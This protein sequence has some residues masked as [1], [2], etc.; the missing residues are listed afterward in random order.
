MMYMIFQFSAQTGEVSGQLS[1]D[2]SYKIVEIKD[3]LLGTEKSYEDLAAEADSIHYY[4]RKAAH[5]TVYFLLAIAVSFPCMYTGCGESGSCF[6]PALSVWVLRDL[7][8]T[9]SP[10]WQGDPSP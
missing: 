10:L 2:I 9:I 6:W 3:E 8:N 1:Y 4:V 7:T 5:M